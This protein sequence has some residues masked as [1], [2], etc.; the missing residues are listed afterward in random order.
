LACHALNFN[1]LQAVSVLGKELHDTRA[2]CAEAQQA[3][4]LKS[5]ELEANSQ[6]SKGLQEQLSQ[7]A[8]ERAA[9]EQRLQVK[10]TENGCLHDKA[11]ASILQSHDLKTK[12]SRLEQEVDHLQK[13][14]V[15]QQQ[16][17]A[18]VSPSSSFTHQTV[19]MHHI[20]C[21]IHWMQG[22]SVTAQCVTDAGLKK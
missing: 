3:A 15:E 16:R 2:T 20:A 18:D 21:S 4:R 17:A 12:N 9:V 8:T 1:L 19:C 7:L 13:S 5:T 6:V 14:L 10:T 22:C 11:M